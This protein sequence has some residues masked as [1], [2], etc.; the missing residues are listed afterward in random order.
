ME[1]RLAAEHQQNMRTLGEIQNDLQCAI[2]E[3]AS[4]RKKYEQ[5]LIEQKKSNESWADMKRDVLKA[6]LIGG[7]FWI[8]GIAGLALW[9][10]IKRSITS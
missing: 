5:T 3:M 6:L 7:L 8:F 9:L 10:Y 2:R 1:T 4:F